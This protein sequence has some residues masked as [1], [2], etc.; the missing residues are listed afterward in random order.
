MNTKLEFGL[1]AVLKADC[2]G[3]RLMNSLGKKN[4]LEQRQKAWRQKR[5]IKSK[6][7]FRVESTRIW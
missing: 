3:R 4:K 6:T 2:Q 7:Y 5:V 1:E